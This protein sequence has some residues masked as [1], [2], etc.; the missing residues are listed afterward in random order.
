MEETKEY[1]ETHYYELRDLSE[2]KQRTCVNQFWEDYAQ[3]LIANYDTQEKER[4]PFLSHNFIYC[5]H[6]IT[7]VLAALSLLD[8]SFSSVEHGFKS[9]E[10]RSAEIKAASNLIL[11]RKEI[12]ESKAEIQND[13]LVAIKYFDLHQLKHNLPKKVEEFLVNEI[14]GCEVLITNVSAEQQN[15]QVLVQIPEGSLPLENSPYQ[16]SH[17]FSLG[18]YTTS[19][20]LFYF[21]FPSRG[22]FKQFPATASINSCIVA[23]SPPTLLKVVQTK[24]ILSDQNF[25]DILQSNSDSRIL[26]FISTKN[27]QKKELDFKFSLILHLLRNRT[28]FTSLIKILTQR[29]IFSHEVF[30]F[31]LYHL[32]IQTMKIYF[33]N[34]KSLSNVLGSSFSN[35]FINLKDN[36]QS[37]RDYYPLIS[38][39]AHPFG[40]SGAA[41][42]RG[43]LAH[44]DSARVQ[45]R[46]KNFRNTY[47]NFL[48]AVIR[49][50][51]EMNDVQNMM[52]VCYLLFQDK[53]TQAQN[54]FQKVNPARLNQQTGGTIQFDYITAFFDMC[55]QKHQFKK[56]RVISEKYLQYPV[57]AWRILFLDIHEQLREFDGIEEEKGEETKK[58]L[59]KKAIRSEV[60]LELKLENKDLHVTF[61]NLD[62]ICI[63]YYEIDLEILFSRSPFLMQNTEYFNFVKPN[64]IENYDVAKSETPDKQIFTIAEEFEEKNVMVEVTGEGKNAFASYFSTN[65]KLEISENFGEIKV[66]NDKNVPQPKVYVKVFAKLYSNET[67]FF[68]DGYTDIRG[69]F[70]YLSLNTS[71]INKVQTFALFV[72]SEKHGIYIWFRFVL[73][74]HRLVN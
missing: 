63:K 65:L 49:N 5:I 27:L 16:K 4:K 52:F 48:I 19:K 10:G 41:S 57:V 61:K 74:M 31:S 55:D 13:I 11:F 44:E 8:L 47:A 66:L 56:A 29:H 26:E 40:G 36:L 62:K 7:E 24:T 68:K 71:N 12:K 43:T 73:I 34:T 28:F 9:S 25:A 60:T 2:S 37:F 42:T 45:I 18:S 58:K 1:G 35:S 50:G 15:F 14:Y 39:R 23:K 20:R 17:S 3:Y 54:V 72:M 46:N 22:M 33:A 59:K 30:A 69:I 67:S 64:K 32:D 70:D 53:V 51:G 38:P 21:Y 6:S